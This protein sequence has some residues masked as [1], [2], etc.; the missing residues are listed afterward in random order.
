MQAPG[1]VTRFFFV[2]T[3]SV[4]YEAEEAL[5]HRG[6]KRCMAGTWQ[7]KWAFHLAKREAR[8]HL[9][10]EKRTKGNTYGSRP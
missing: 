1:K 6:E 10:S 5:W 2:E 9:Y 4:Y 7:R 3:D 8:S